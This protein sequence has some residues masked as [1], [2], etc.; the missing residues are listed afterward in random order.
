GFFCCGYVDRGA[1]CGVFVGVLNVLNVL[2][3]QY[4]VEV[5]YLGLFCSPQVVARN[6]LVYKF[7]CE[8]LTAA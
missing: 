3:G 5:N 2:N 8:V 7:F 6:I 4:G 1:D